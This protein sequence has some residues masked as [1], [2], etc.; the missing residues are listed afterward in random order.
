MN[1]MLPL[2]ARQYL[3]WIE[4]AYLDIRG[5]DQMTISIF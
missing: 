2:S 1:F 5:Q 4:P 3:S